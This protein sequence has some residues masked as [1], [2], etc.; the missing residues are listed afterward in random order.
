MPD[1]TPL[2][3]GARDHLHAL[4]PVLRTVDNG[5]SREQATRILIAE[6]FSEEEIPYYLDM[7]LDRGYLYCVEN[8]LFLTNP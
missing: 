4:R 7:L 6:G 3:P 1:Q 2:P 8:Y 5:L